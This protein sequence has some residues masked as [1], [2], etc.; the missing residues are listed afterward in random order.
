MPDRSTE[1]HYGSISAVVKENEDFSVYS[2]PQPKPSMMGTMDINSTCDD[3]KV[4][5]NLDTH[6]NACLACILFNNI[7]T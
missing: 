7:Y 4:I 3:G 1:E 5:F 2:M 6:I